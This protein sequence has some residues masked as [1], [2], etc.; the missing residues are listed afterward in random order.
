MLEITS[1]DSFYQLPRTRTVPYKRKHTS[2]ATILNKQF[3]LQ[4]FS[5]TL[6][7]LKSVCA[8]FCNP[9]RS[10]ELRE[11]SQTSQ[12]LFYATWNHSARFII[13]PFSVLSFFPL[14]VRF[15]SRFRGRR[16]GWKLYQSWL[17]MSLRNASSQLFAGSVGPKKCSGVFWER[18][19]K[20][21]CK[22]AEVPLRGVQNKILIQSLDGRLPYVVRTSNWVILV[23]G[24]R[25]QALW[26]DT[27]FGA[28]GSG[29]G[30]A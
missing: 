13:Y 2:F 9:S 12:V 23:N 17:F 5:F 7:V 30:S 3:S 24:D 11:F 8:K 6:S 16:R 27:C 14:Q 21:R 22:P 25:S 1:T 20:K 28:C 4:N 10:L 15:I 29:L 19:K 18:W 26:R